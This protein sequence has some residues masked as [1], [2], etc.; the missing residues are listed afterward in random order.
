MLLDLCVVGLVPH[1]PPLGS[2]FDPSTGVWTILAGDGPSTSSTLHLSAM[3]VGATVAFDAQGV[4]TIQASDD[5]DAM[6]AEGYVTAR[7]R[8]LE[9]DLER[10][11]G[12]GTLSAVVGGAAL[13]SDELQ[14]G[15]G[16]E[17]TAQ[18]EWNS[19]ARDSALRAMLV[20][21]S[22]GVNEAITYLEDHDQLPAAMRLL[23]YRP[24][25]WTPVD[26]PARNPHL[27]RWL[28]AALTLGLFVTAFK[29]ST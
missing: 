13:S 18:A 26:T 8:L 14:L 4:A 24:S 17:R 3:K 12:E 29:K 7:N 25:A 19:L 21:Y 6:V 15:L 23:D 5:Y 1:L 10:R 2:A 28:L 11:L 20:A 9:M 16:L 27:L 22:D